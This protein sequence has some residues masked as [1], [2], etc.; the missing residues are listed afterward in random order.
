MGKSKG[1][2]LR[3]TP[4]VPYH[5]SV[6]GVAVNNG[7]IAVINKKRKDLTL[8]RETCYLYESMGDCL[9]KGL[10]EEMGVR[11]EIGGF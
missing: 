2:E 1:I 4:K 11:G 8:A 6:G 9:K 7:K 3:G 10:Q 5:F